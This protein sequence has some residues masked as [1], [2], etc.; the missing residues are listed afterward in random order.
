MRKKIFPSAEA[1][2]AACGSV[3]T[4][5]VYRAER[6]GP[7]L[8][9]YL[10][11]MAR[12]LDVD[13]DRLIDD[14]EPVDGAGEPHNLTGSWVGL[15]IGADRFGQPYLIQE[16]AD[17]IQTG[18][19]VHGHTTIETR[20]GVMLDRLEDCFLTDNVFSGQTRSEQ[21]PFP[22]DCAAFVTSGI[23]NLTRLD[24]YISWFDLDTERPE[25]S[26]YL[27][28]RRDSPRFDSDVA[29]ARAMLDN[30]IKLMRIRRL[31]EAGYNFDHAADLIP[32]ADTSPALAFEEHTRET[33]VATVNTADIPAA[34]QTSQRVIAV[35]SLIVLD[36]DPTQKFYADG[37]ID[38]IAT[39]LAQTPG[40]GI[41]PRSSF[42]SGAP[43][44]TKTALS[45]NASHVL[46]GSLQRSDNLLRVNAQLVEANSGR[47][48]WAE[49]YE[50][51]SERVFAAHD[52]ISR[53]VA[54]AL[55]L[56]LSPT[57]LPE[58]A[59]GSP[60]PH[61]Y[62][63]FLKARSLYLRGIYIHSLKA[64]EALLARAV[65]I[66]PEF[67]RG[68]AQISICRSHLVLSNAQPT[69]L[70]HLEDGASAAVR[71][72]EI[73]PNLALGHAALGLVHY[74]AGDYQAAE[75]ALRKSIALDSQLFEAHFFLAR[76]LRLQGDRSGAAKYFAHA[77]DLRQ[78]D[79]RATGLLGEELQALDREDEA[80][81]KF[82]ASLRSVEHELEGHPDNAGALAFGAAVLSDLGEIDR[83]ATWSEWALAIAPDDC[84]VQ[85]NIARSFAI[86]GDL[87]AAMSHLNR[88][89]K[90]AAK[91]R[92]RL[93]LWMKFDEDFSKL[94]DKTEFHDLFTK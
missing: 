55:R 63:L 80:Q 39:E 85:Y 38:D 82:R 10:A 62:E 64:A 57:P 15:Y 66:D 28:I 6:G 20:E 90:V 91:H 81:D 2:A 49:R 65:E 93:G 1:F 58:T 22:L 18:K 83:A 3:S 9:S 79:F 87:A 92:R 16:K 21:W 76:D 72:L 44:D 75:A 35:S 88:A 42:P 8:K 17:L 68:H 78:E 4:P 89:F 37:L 31:L 77:S 27:L 13:M 84:L 7:V 94:A 48:V 30:E 19:S 70:P 26:R 11:A 59:V 12:Q 34:P 24:G 25:S 74:A 32:E 51:H 54:A 47:I 73:N 46:N 52:D 40:L 67:A 36:A 23:R 86:N 45:R 56:E 5:T 53:D 50:H 33:G 69:G 61:A 71:A 60:N 41:L 14:A 43:V 29:E